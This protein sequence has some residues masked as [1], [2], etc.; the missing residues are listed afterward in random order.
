ME[1]PANPRLHGLNSRHTLQQVR[2]TV[3][4][5][6]SRNLIPGAFRCLQ[7]GRTDVSPRPLRGAPQPQSAARRDLSFSIIPAAAIWIAEDGNRPR[8]FG[9]QTLP[10]LANLELR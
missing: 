10:G 6:E 4:V 3:N 2:Q 7:T 9:A 5:A 8:Y 1:G